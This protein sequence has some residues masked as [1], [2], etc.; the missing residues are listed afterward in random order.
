MTTHYRQATHDDT[1]RIMEIIHQAQARMRAAGSSQWQNGYPAL[2]NIASD[3]DGCHA[4]V[5]YEEGHTQTLGTHNAEEYILAYAAVI[6]DAEPAYADIE[7]AWLCTG[8]YVV[9]HR[10]AVAEEAIQQGVATNFLR[11]IEAMARTRGCRSFR[12]DTAHENLHMQHLTASLGFTFCGE[13][14]YESDMRLAYEKP[15]SDEKHKDPA[16]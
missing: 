15:L 14:R 5:A 10:L 8:D 13:I 4:V 1:E 7:G 9:V 3:I 6:F 2:Y 16:R 11:H 12:I